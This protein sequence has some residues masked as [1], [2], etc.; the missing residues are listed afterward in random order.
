MTQID[1]LNILF[2]QHPE[3]ALVNR[4]LGKGKGMH[5]L[6]AGLHASARALALTHV[7]EPLFIILDNSEAAQYLYGDLKTLG[8]EVL[9][10]PSGKR[11]RTVDEAM[12]IQ[13]TETLS[14]LASTGRSVERLII[15][16]YPE[17]V[18]EPVPA[19]DKL[20]AISFQLA[21]G[22]E[23]Q[24]T[25]LSEQLTE[26]GF[27]H[28]DFVFQ[29]GQYAIRGSIVDIYSYS[30]DNPYRFDFFG[31]EIDSIREFDIEDQLSKAKVERAEITGSSDVESDKESSTII[32]YLTEAYVWVSNSWQVAQYKLNGLGLTRDSLSI[33]S[34]CTIE[35][36][37]KSSLLKEPNG[38]PEAY[39]KI[40]FDTVPQPVFH[41]QFDILTED[42]KQHIEEGYKIYILAEQT[43]QLD[44][45]KAISNRLRTRNDR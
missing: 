39:S 28:V 13:R 16:T 31:D 11:R 30:H 20:S 25:K 18:A 22:Q 33:S 37:E 23:I 2:G 44:R 6:L 40:S 36:G 10:F 29:P 34:R 21:V 1:D 9:F 42:L 5:L 17:A 19:K 8:A 7:K 24:Q 3:L 32:D 38:A 45:L 15:V 26:L 12:M 35:F 43:K 41:K 4:E 27:E 14:A